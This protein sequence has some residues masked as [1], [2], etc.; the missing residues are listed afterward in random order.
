M[1]DFFK[2]NKVILSIILLIGICLRFLDINSPQGIW[3]DEYRVFSL[4]VLKSNIDFFDALRTNSYAPLHSFYLRIWNVVFKDSD[5]MLRLSSLIPNILGCLVMYY[6]GKN[7]PTKNNSVNIGLYACVLCSISSFLI[8]FS[9]ESKIYSM[10]FLLSSLILLYSIKTFENPSKK[11]FIWLCSLSILLILEHTIGFVFV[12][13]NIFGLIAFGVFKNKGKGK[14]NKDDDAIMPVVAWVMLV[15]PLAPFVVKLF[16]HPSFLSWWKPFNWSRVFFCFTDWFS[17]V[18]KNVTVALQN[19]FYNQIIL[20]DKIDYGFVLFALVPSLICLSLIVKS[21]IESK[22]INKYLLT[23]CVSTF[24]T[25]VITTIALK[26]TFLTKYFVELYPILILM[27][28]LGFNEL[29]SLN[30]RITLGTVYVFMSLFYIITC[31][32][33]KVL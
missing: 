25:I 27:A 22:K 11:N 6:A 28:A 3:S 12:I 32:I 8:Y 15:L 10:I 1:K 30:T 29:K 14:K 31:H 13:F 7:F 16:A 20:N 19:S 17:P 21:N 24:L 26:L 4:D 18:L 23:V 9:L 33:L 2:N 5:V